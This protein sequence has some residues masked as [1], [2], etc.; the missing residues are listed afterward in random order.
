LDQLRLHREKKAPRRKKENVPHQGLHQEGLPQRLKKD[1]FVLQTSRRIDY[2]HTHRDERLRKI[3]SNQ[4]LL[5][6]AYKE[7]FNRETRKTEKKPCLVLLQLRCSS[8]QRAIIQQIKFFNTEA[9]K[10][11]CA[12]KPI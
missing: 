1:L 6:S 8:V 2:T 3:I 4:N 10:D 12:E 11:C 5:G 7:S 9:G